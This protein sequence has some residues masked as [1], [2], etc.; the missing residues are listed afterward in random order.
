MTFT[1]FGGNMMGESSIH[2]RERTK[3][4]LRGCGQ[5]PLSIDLLRVKTGRYGREA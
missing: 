5:D 4:T 3:K 1:Y 2:L